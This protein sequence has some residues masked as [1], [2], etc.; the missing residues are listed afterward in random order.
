[1]GWMN[2]KRVIALRLF[3]IFAG[4]SRRAECAAVGTVDVQGWGNVGLSLAG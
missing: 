4:V 3:G 2:L 1:M